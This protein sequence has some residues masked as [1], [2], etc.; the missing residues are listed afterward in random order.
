MKF[1][2]YKDKRKEWRWHLKAGNGKIV[3]IG[4]GYKKRASAVKTIN[5]IVKQT[6]LNGRFIPIVEV[7]K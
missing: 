7:K 6:I 5:M 1:E 3:A 2:V 4:E